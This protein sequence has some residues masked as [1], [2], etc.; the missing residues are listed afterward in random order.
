[1]Q[2]DPTTVG[3]YVIQ[4]A[5]GRGAMGAIYK[6]HDPDIDRPVAIKLIRADLL[7]SSERDSF[8]ARFRRE[9]RAAGRCQHPNIIAL[10]DFSLHE[11]NPFLAMEFVDGLTLSQS[12]PVGGR[13]AAE[14]TVFVALQLLAALQAAHAAGIVHRDIKPANLMLVGGSHVKVADFGIARLDT[15]QLTQRESVIGTPSYMSP[16][17]CRGEAVDG[18]SDLFST[19]VLLFEMLAGQ[20]PFAGA[21][22]A[23]VL[24]KLLRDPPPDLRALVPG[25]PEA[26]VAVVER[27]LAKDASE[28]FASAVDMAAA[29]KLAAEASGTDYDERT[30]IA[31]QRQAAPDARPGSQTSATTFDPQLLDTLSRK[32]AEMLGPIAPYL[33]Q[34][35]LRRATSVEAL[36][37]ELESKVDL[38]TDRLAFQAEVRRQL[39]RSRNA[40]ATQQAAR[41][42]GTGGR[43][44]LGGTGGPTDAASA[45]VAPISAA[46]IERVQTALARH[47]G[48]MA[49]V[50]IKRA[51]ANAMSTAALRDSLAAQIPDEPG[52]Q[53]FLRELAAV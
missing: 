43:A 5:L 6:A 30:L 14:D 19:G 31:P 23:E 52:R 41:T 29:L 37:A 48:P 49:R 35:A 4:G 51:L 18:R 25:I 26:L 44:A 33:V 34:S 39:E 32:L 24:T 53:A 15:S 7:E 50:M 20:K 45:S 38:P 21:T 13:F 40:G 47:V 8:I 22:S 11:G 16:E 36:C 27:S 28:R 2:A 1:M 46:D 42:G 10:Y 17:Q 3:R 12:R 9:A